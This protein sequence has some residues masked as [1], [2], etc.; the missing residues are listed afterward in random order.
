[1]RPP[2]SFIGSARIIS[3]DTVVEPL[4]VSKLHVWAVDQ[5]EEASKEGGSIDQLEEVLPD[6]DSIEP[7]R[8]ESAGGVAS[9]DHVFDPE[10]V[11]SSC[12]ISPEL[13]S[14]VPL[15]VSLNSGAAEQSES[16]ILLSVI[17][18]HF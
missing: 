4:A 14:L 3:H 6:P 1:M 9:L 16:T 5:E 17:I 8:V 12:I 7:E 10:E 18:T 13:D 2:D 15:P 11:A